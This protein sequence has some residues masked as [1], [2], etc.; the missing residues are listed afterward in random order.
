MTSR[1]PGTAARVLPL[2]AVAAACTVPAGNL[3]G[4]AA[5]ETERM[6]GIMWL[7]PRRDL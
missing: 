3:T 1:L 4:R 5:D 2:A 6:E 7:D